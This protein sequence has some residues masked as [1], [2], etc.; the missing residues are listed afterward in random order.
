MSG[1][2]REQDLNAIRAAYASYDA[3]HRA[4]LWDPR[5]R[6]FARAR[7]ESDRFLIHLIRT[8]AAQFP[9][10]R[11]I[12]VGCGEG[13]MLKMARDSGASADWYGVDLLADRIDIATDVLPDGHFVVASAD[14]TPFSDASFD[15]ALAMTLFSSIPSRELEDAVASEITRIVRPGGYLIWY[16]IRYSNP[17][18]PRVHGLSVDRIR[19]LFPAWHDE[20]DTFTVAPP[21]ARRL[22]LLTPVAYPVLHAIPVLRSHLIGRL[23]KTS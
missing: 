1:V 18:N 23:Q 10:A 8:L 22:G 13:R 7:H 9:A 15:I 3:E 4:R 16:D 14:S 17:S 21:I 5:N 12:D 2:R 6:G 19:A 20:L 11:V